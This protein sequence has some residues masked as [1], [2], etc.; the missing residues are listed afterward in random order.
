MPGYESF[1]K[2]EL[3]SIDQLLHPAAVVPDLE[4]DNK[5]AYL[6]MIP[7][8]VWAGMFEDWLEMEHRRDYE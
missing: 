7:R 8:N 2:Q 4:N 6:R 1:N 3:V 5:R